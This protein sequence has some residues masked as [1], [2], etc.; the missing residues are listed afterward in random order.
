MFCQPRKAGRIH[1]TVPRNNGF[2]TQH[3]MIKAGG[4]REP[5]RKPVDDAAFQDFQAKLFVYRTPPVGEPQ[6]CL[7]ASM[8][9]IPIARV[10]EDVGIG[11]ATEIQAQAGAIMYD[12][13]AKGPARHHKSKDHSMQTNLRQ[14][15]NDSGESSSSLYTS[16]DPLQCA[17][18]T[19]DI[20]EPEISP[21]VSNSADLG[22]GQG[23]AVE[24]VMDIDQDEADSAIRDMNTGRTIYAGGKNL[25]GEA[26]VQSQQSPSGMSTYM[27]VGPDAEMDIS[28]AAFPSQTYKPIPDT[29]DWMDEKMLND[30]LHRQSDEGASNGL[31][32]VDG[33]SMNDVQTHVSND[34]DDLFC[35]ESTTN[36]ANGTSS[37]DA[38]LDHDS[39]G[40]SQTMIDNV[41]DVSHFTNQLDEHG[42][43]DLSSAEPLEDSDDE[44]ISFISAS[45]DEAET[46]PTTD[47][48][49][50]SV[51]SV[52]VTPEENVTDI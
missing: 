45:E 49:T 51:P 26:F 47:G 50:K 11:E 37:E 4:S 9:P 17:F 29:F 5:T 39:F 28:D 52:N 2:I 43:Q 20:A 1:E 35:G 7:A 10:V 30:V 19:S 46:V 23:N 18:G 14:A 33:I 16:G 6:G 27:P 13:A 3:D 48:D 15:E 22:R 32:I 21:Y 41:G 24:E 36:E 12:E 31:S 8:T 38:K 40:S 42:N 44:A 34:S 25:G